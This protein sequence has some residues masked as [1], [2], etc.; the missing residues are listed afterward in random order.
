MDPSIYGRRLLP[1]LIDEIAATDPER[2]YLSLPKTAEPQEGYE[3]INFR[4]FAKAINRCSWWIEDHVGKAQQ[5]FPT[6]AYIGPQDPRYLILI[7]ACVKT[8]YKVSCNSMVKVILMNNVSGLQ[9]FVP[10]PRNN[11]ETNLSL[12]EALDCNA[13]FVP[14]GPAPVLEIVKQIESRRPL[15]TFSVQ[16]LTQMLEPAHIPA[17]EY[18]KTFEKAKNEP[19]VVEHTSGSTGTPQAIVVSQRII[20][21]MD[22]TQKIHLLGGARTHSSYW[23]GLKA[24]MP[25][26]MFHAAGLDMLASAVYTKM[27]IVLPPT[28]PLT[29]D[30]ADAVHRSTDIDLTIL[31]PSIFADIAANPE[32]LEKL[33]DIRL[34]CYGGGPIPPTAG[35]KIASRTHLHNGFGSTEAGWYALEMPDPEDWQYLNFSPIIGHEMRH[36][37]AD[38]YELCIVRD[39]KLE[40]FQPIFSIFPQLDVYST[41]DLF[42]KHPRKAGLWMSRGRRDDVIVYSTGEKMDPSSFEGSLTGHPDVKGALIYGQGR[43]QSALLIEARNPPTNNTEKQELSDKLWPLIQEA[44]LVSPAY[45]RVTPDMLLIAT[46]EKP[47]PRASKGTIQRKLVYDIYSEELNELYEQNNQIMIKRK[48]GEPETRANTLQGTILQVIQTFPGMQSVT[49]TDDLFALALDSLQVL[50]LNRRI[51][52]CLAHMELSVDRVSPRTIYSSRSVETLVLS[53]SGDPGIQYDPLTEMES[54]YSEYTSE[55]LLTARVDTKPARGQHKVMLTGSTGSLGSYILD[56]LLVDDSINSIYCLNRDTSARTRQADSMRAKGLLQDFG[57]KDVQFLQIDFSKP[58]LG[59]ERSIYMTLL[60]EVTLIIH[61]AWTVDFN[62]PLEQ[63]APIHVRGVRQMIDFSSRSAHGAHIFFLSSIG[64]VMN[65]NYGTG[66]AN[67]IPEEVFDAWEIAESTGYSQAKLVAERILATAAT[68]SNIGVTICRIGQIAG[69]SAKAGEW[70][71]QEWL[72]SILASSKMIGSLPSSLGAHEVVDWTPVDAVASSV[73]RLAKSS[74]G[75]HETLTVYHIVNPQR[76][77]WSQILPAIQRH[78]GLNT[79]EPSQWLNLL[80]R[81]S[82]DELDIGS[83]PALKLIEFL[84][85]ALLKSSSE[86]PLPL[87]VESTVKVDP[88]LGKL[89]AIDEGLITLW[90]NQWNF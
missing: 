78:L 17:Y 22:A 18:S 54:L 53:L 65:W 68:H 38:L 89:G 70:P 83:N 4:S 74:A 37:D 84:E 15:R 76:T 39:P 56:K 31:P 48:S 11:L 47:F 8:G 81:S 61:N 3:D 27:S 60:A 44:N 87:S 9:L 16:A 55:P 52:A 34:A 13:F 21:A 36:F 7:L 51:K 24:F 43:F 59:L 66:T 5:G 62:R 20:T 64:A 57:G 12:L 72:P 42:S 28:T 90:L 69:P 6:I 73:L 23:H 75:D 88:K 79:V 2:I 80:R 49:A 14:E 26:P 41:K 67:A 32:F 29:A 35:E 46:L 58:Y 10:S 85:R 1:S 50:T 63:L 30:L 19:F 33:K 25:F 77:T 82:S 40:D 45:G 86:K 71:K